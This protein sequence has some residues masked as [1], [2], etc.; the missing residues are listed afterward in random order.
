LPDS[1]TLADRKETFTIMC[2]TCTVKLSVQTLQ[3]YNGKWISFSSPLAKKFL[4]LPNF[5]PTCQITTHFTYNTYW[6]K[7]PPVE[8]RIHWSSIFGQ[9]NC[10]VAA[11]CSTVFKLDLKYF[12]MVGKL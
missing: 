6:N 3:N 8:G 7:F 10:L 2:N 12:S 5:R 11:E 9:W 1:R 4:V